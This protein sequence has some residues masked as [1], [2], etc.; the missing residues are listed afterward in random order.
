VESQTPAGNNQHVSTLIAALRTSVVHHLGDSI[1]TFNLCHVFSTHLHVG[2][3]NGVQ[4]L[5]TPEE[6]ERDPESCLCAL[7]GA[8]ELSGDLPSKTPN[9]VSAFNTDFY[10]AR[11]SY[12]QPPYKAPLVLARIESL[13]MGALTTLV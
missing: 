9:E 5:A 10:R 13:L 2:T 4:F 12:S 3:R 1:L 6:L 11:G 8:L 7:A